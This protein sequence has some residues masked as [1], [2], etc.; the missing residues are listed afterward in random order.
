M[1]AVPVVGVVGRHNS[2]KTT[3]LL[4]LLPLLVSRGLRVGYL[5][6]AHAGFE[7]DRPEKDSYRARRT[8]VLQTIVTGGGQTAVID[9]AGD[10]PL[11]QVIERYARDD[12]DL[13][14]VEGFKRE[15]MPK[16]EVARRAISAG[17]L[18]CDDDPLLLGVVSDFEP[19]RR[20]VPHFAPH[21]AAAVADL[22]WSAVLRRDER[23]RA[24]S[25]SAAVMAGGKSRRMGRDKA[26]LDVGDGRPIVRRVIDV[27]AEVA[28]EVF[29]VANDDRY[30][31]LGLRVV[32]DR[33]PDGGVLG[34]IATALGAAVHDRVLVAACDMPLLRPDVFRLLVA[35]SEGSDAVVPRVGGEYETLHALYSKACLAPIERALASGRLR[36]ISFFDDVRVRAIDEAELRA[37]DPDLASFTN[38]NTPEELAAVTKR[39]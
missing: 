18:V 8:G 30:R 36:V 6:H 31:G 35:R 25:V 17:E 13:I 34:G 21:D 12:L 32:A 26:W 10:V 16:I 37:V 22:I 9:D 38:V 4:T 24:M 5:K 33:F 1:T 27:L 28:D 39:A 15:H 2:G 14:V 11:T 3:F 23:P 19:P 7:I 20:D 29:I